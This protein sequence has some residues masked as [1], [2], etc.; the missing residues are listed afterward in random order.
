M[1]NQY[2]RFMMIDMDK[3]MVRRKSAFWACVIALIV[4]IGLGQGWA[5]IQKRVNGPHFCLKWD[6]KAHEYKRVVE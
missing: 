3:P 1:S 6:Q 5:L 2:P 4:G